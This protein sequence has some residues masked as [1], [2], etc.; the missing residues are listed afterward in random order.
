MQLNLFGLPFLCNT[1]KSWWDPKKTEPRT[2]PSDE[3][4]VDMDDPYQNYFDRTYPPNA[5]SSP[6][7]KGDESVPWLH[8]TLKGTRLG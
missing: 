3:S 1:K 6:P 8:E 7:E 4:G 5:P 2:S